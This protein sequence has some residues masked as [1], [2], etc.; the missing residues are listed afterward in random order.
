[1]LGFSNEITRENLIAMGNGA[2]E[3]KVSENWGGGEIHR[4]KRKGFTGQSAETWGALPL[5]SL[6]RLLEAWGLWDITCC[7]LVTKS[8]PILRNPMDCSKPGSSVGFPRQEYWILFPSPGDLLDAE[9]EPKSS[10]SPELLVDSL[11]LSHQGKP[12][13]YCLHIIKDSHCICT[14]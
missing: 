4:T 5:E 10:A 13:G 2:W 9:T 8:G 1:M 12:R 6:R 14:V 3:W 7:C 11:T